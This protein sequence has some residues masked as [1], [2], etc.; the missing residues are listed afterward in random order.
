MAL[1]RRARSGGLARL[2]VTDRPALQAYGVPV[3]LAGASLGLAAATT[4]WNENAFYA[5]MLA[6]VTLSVWYAGFAPGMLA[7]VVSWVGAWFAIQE[8]RWSFGAPDGSLAVSWALGL[9]LSLLIVAWGLATQL[10]QTRAEGRVRRAE[11]ARSVTVAAQSLTSALSSAVTPSDVAAVLVERLPR[12][13]GASGCALGLVEGDALVIVDPQGAPQQSLAPGRR[14]PLVTRAP[15]TTAARSGKPAF[16]RTRRAFERDFPDGA[17]LAPAAAGAL[18]VPLLSSGTPVGAIGLPF[19]RRNA[20]SDETVEFAEL[21]AELGGQALERARLYERERAL[22]AGLDRVARLVPRLGDLLPD[23]VAAQLCHEARATLDADEVQLWAVMDDGFERIERDAAPAAGPLPQ[24]ARDTSVARYL[25][26]AVEHGR[27]ARSSGGGG[28]VL[29]VPVVS[30]AGV[31]HVVSFHWR[32]SGQAPAESTVAVARRFAEQAGLALEQAARREAQSAA[33]RSAAETRRLLDATA[34]FAAATSVVDVADATLGEA[35]RALGTDAGAVVRLLDDG[36]HLELVAYRGYEADAVAPWQR[37]PVDAPMPLAEAVRRNTLVAVASRDEL[38]RRFPS[39]DATSSAS[40]VSVP[41]VA[42]G[43][44]VGALGLSFSD[45]RMVSEEEREFLLSIARQAGQA[46]DRSLLFDEEARARVRAERM[47]RKLA[48]LHALARTMG[49][50]VTENEVVDAIATEV[51]RGAQADA[52]DVYSI[53]AE[54]G[55]ATRLGHGGRRTT[56]SLEPALAAASE[57]PSEAVRALMSGV[58]LWQPDVDDWQAL[59]GRRAWE[60]NGLAAI[61]LVPLAAAGRTVGVLAVAFERHDGLDEPR[62]TFIETVARQAGIPLERV[63]LLERERAARQAAERAS[64]RTRRLQQVTESLAAALTVD[65]VARAVAEAGPADGDVVV[66]TFDPGQGKLELAGAAG[67]TDEARAATISL[68]AAH[69]AVDALR[70]RQPVELRSLHVVPARYRPFVGSLTGGEGRGLLFIP[71]GEGDR[72]LGVLQIEYTPDALGDDE[73]GLAFTLARQSAQALDRAL[74]YE[75]ERRTAETLQRSMLPDVLP[76]MEGLASTARYIPG[77][78]RVDVGGD[79]YDMIALADGSVCLVV[80][81]VVGK[82]VTAAATM[83]QLRN[84]L[85]AIA[86][87]SSDPAVIVTKLNRLLTGLAEAPFATLCVVTIDSSTL[88]LRIVAAGHPPPLVVSQAGDAAYLE[89]GR[90]LPLGVEADTTYVSGQTRLEPGSTVLLYTDGLVER[91]DRPLDQGLDLL[92]TTARTL[93]DELSTYV[94]GVLSAMIGAGGHGDDVAV[95]A[96]RIDQS[97]LEPLEL[98]IRPESHALPLMRAELERWLADAAVAG[99]D[100][101][102]IVLATWEAGANAVEHAHLSPE[103]TVRVRAA[104]VRDAVEVEVSDSGR[105]KEPE[106]R[107]D[108]G[109]GLRLINELMTDLTVEREAH[110][111]RVLM[112]RQLSRET[113]SNGLGSDG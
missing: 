14:F 41:L 81:D 93:A 24:P 106:Q 19:S 54:G 26:E 23:A 64:E 73:R 83:A 34:S 82:G 20:F 68:A 3:A 88:E 27:P 30:G 77:S 113:P 78:A 101:R 44:V 21:A 90:G 15:I 63:R 17:L 37:F 57:S 66:Y 112:R 12:V 61:G 32:T 25:T 51:V 16:A 35:F 28:S 97:L 105:W 99:S 62:R 65:E 39:L 59:G 18:A 86:L 50:S 7:V 9:G 13:L 11:R 74:L 47:A 4:G 67:D 33:A 84:G 1:V 104:F 71:L 46:L 52:V 96:V 48:Q 22:S 10:A 102:D 98:A 58:P 45:P 85:R 69:P 80:G 107:I 108:R 111:T 70:R 36:T 2:T 5:P 40:W 49:Q 43:S 72:T 38:G 95:L 55:A 100:A 110:G 89:S 87:D 79:W 6:A 103:E 92:E 94:D 56:P 29:C 60:E 31:E 8:P 91:R 109:L 42:A 75:A 76:V 53:P